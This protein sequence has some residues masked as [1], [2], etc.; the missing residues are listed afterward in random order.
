MYED[1]SRKLISK[2]I[3]NKR[4]K[5]LTIKAFEVIKDACL[6]LVIHE[7]IDCDFEYQVRL[8][9]STIIDFVCEKLG[10]QTKGYMFDC[11]LG[12]GNS[13]YL[14]PIYASRL[15]KSHCDEEERFLRDIDYKLLSVLVC[16]YIKSKGFK[17]RKAVHRFT[18]ENLEIMQFE[19]SKYKLNQL[20]SG[21]GEHGDSDYSDNDTVTTT[22]RSVICLSIIAIIFFLCYMVK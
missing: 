13:L 22:L 16:N 19:I 3:D 15:S 21:N 14:S 12:V 17:S 20:I 9:D 4:R 11:R 18:N 1:A 7:T 6:K 8:S 10:Y 2:E 5:E